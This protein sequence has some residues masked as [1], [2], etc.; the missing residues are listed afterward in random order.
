MSAKGVIEGANASL[1][2]SAK[3]H[4]ATAC[5]FHHVHIYMFGPRARLVIEIL[6][7]GHPS[8]RT[9]PTRWD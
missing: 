3:R 1:G 5:P 9:K 7:A 4:V 8:I 2:I 6:G